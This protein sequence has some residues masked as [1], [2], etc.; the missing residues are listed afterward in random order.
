M[1]A[2]PRR[3]AE[4]YCSSDVTAEGR[5]LNFHGARGAG[6]EKSDFGGKGKRGWRDHVEAMPKLGLGVIF[7][8]RNRLVRNH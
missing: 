6:G 3:R 7:D 8:D 4:F 1:D 2:P 5:D